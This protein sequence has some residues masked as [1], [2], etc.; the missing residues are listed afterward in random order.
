MNATHV[1]RRQ[2]MKRAIRLL[3][4]IGLLWNLISNACQNAWAQ[5]KRVIL[6]KGT[7][8]TGLVHRNPATLDTRNLEVIP[9]EKFETMGLTDHEVDLATWRLEIT[10]TVKKPLKLTYSQ[11]LQMPVLARNVLL[12]C[13]G[14]FTNHGQWQGVSIAQLLQAAEA[15]SGITHVSIRGPEGRYAK[16]ERFPIAEIVSDKVFLAYQVNGQVLP[17]KHGY[18]L[19]VVA[20]DHYGSD[21]VKFVHHIEA[22]KIN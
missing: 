2:F 20:E 16:V 17:Q 10:G 12:I 22:H 19:R 4:G 7:S 8:M 5:T 1:P 6:P 21:W 15:Q 14:F 3:A 11:L 9:L 13:P 18:P